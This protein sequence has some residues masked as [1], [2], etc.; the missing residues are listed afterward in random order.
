MDAAT[1]RLAVVVVRPYHE[2]IRR[3]VF[4]LLGEAGYEP[5]HIIEPGTPDAEAVERVRALRLH[6][7]VVPFHGHRTRDGQ[8]VD[9][10]SFLRALFLV[11]PEAPWRVLM[12]VSNFG[13]G[14]VEIER[15]KCPPHVVDTVMFLMEDELPKSQNAARIGRHFARR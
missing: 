8:P 13:A 14:A 1:T 2:R 6:R 4:K 11:A 3:Q 7:L 5:A 12:P 9:G 10:F 15:S